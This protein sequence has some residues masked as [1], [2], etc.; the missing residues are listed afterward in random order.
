MADGIGSAVVAVFSAVCLGYA[1]Q[2][3]AE[4]F[5]RFRDGSA[6]AASLAGELSSYK[7]AL[8]ILRD[9]LHSWLGLI[10]AGKR[11]E[12]M[13]RPF[14]RPVD[15]V[16]DQSVGK[17]GLLGSVTVENVV[18]VYSNLRAFRVAFEMV[19]AMGA[20]MTD[21]EIQSRL[22]RCLQALERAAERGETLIPELQSRAVRPF[23]LSWMGDR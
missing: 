16:F 22:D 18:F 12:L 4:D 3:V 20:D 2:F 8:P 17:L 13:L 1:T 21:V 5:R 14:E 15:V 6:L 19:N 10:A 23:R 9:I 7:P 11:T